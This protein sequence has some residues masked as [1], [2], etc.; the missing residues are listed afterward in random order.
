MSMMFDANGFTGLTLDGGTV[1]TTSEAGRVYALDASS[2]DLLWQYDSGEDVFYPP[3][4]VDGVVYVNSQSGHDQPLGY[5][6]ALTASTGELIWKYETG[7]AKYSLMTESEGVV[8]VGSG[9]GSVSAVDASNGELLWRYDFGYDSNLPRD[10]VVD[11]GA[12]FP[13]VVDG[14]VYVGIR[15]RRHIRARRIEWVRST[16][17]AP[18]DPEL[19][20]VHP[21]GELLWQVRFP[22]NELMSS[23]PTVADGMVY[24]ALY[25][26]SLHALD[27]STGSLVWSYVAG[28]WIYS[29]PMVSDGVVYAGSGDG[30]VYALDASNGELLWRYQ[31]GDTVFYPPVA[32]DDVVYAVSGVQVYALD[33]LTG[34]MLWRSELDGH[35]T[36]FPA[37]VDGTLYAG[38][39]T[40][41]LYALDASNGQE[42]W[43]YKVADESYSLPSVA[44]GIAY[45]GA[46]IGDVGYVY[47]LDASTGALIWQYETSTSAR[48]SPV[49]D[50]G[51]VYASGRFD[52]H[53]HA[54]DALSGE[55]LWQYKPGWGISS[56]AVSD[57]VVYAD[58][59]DGYIY[60]LNSSTG[61]PRWRAVG[62]A[63]RPMLSDGA[64]Y[65]GYPLQIGDGF[66]D[67]VSALDSET[68]EILWTYQ[69]AV[70]LGRQATV[71][72]G[73]LYLTPTESYY[74]RDRGYTG[75]Y[76]YAVTGPGAR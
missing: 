38:S 14:I 70:G 4:V 64:I 56:L 31:T 24:M 7:D 53:I 55:L 76:L 21:S 35:V 19:G 60:A 57:G 12:T 36:P 45:V 6:H 75:Y 72:D 41:Y 66:I 13:V 62:N 49:V 68:G 20:Q 15:G 3:T 58:A 52:G 17:V 33:A 40:G 51:V 18:P 9:D 2:G 23:N 43:R 8:Y 1:Y 73:V 50:A 54:L 10:F 37:L 26:N 39:L 25:D 44:G 5:V 48:N 22:V 42:L 71:A 11:R 29:S 28:D 46:D 69:A 27:A 63:F 61:E 65:T 32:L 59:N 47:A 74:D 67:S 30:Y 16:G 34:E